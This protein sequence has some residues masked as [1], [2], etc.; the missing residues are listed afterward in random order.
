MIY[1]Y[2]ESFENF[3]QLFNID[4]DIIERIDEA[5]MD[6]EGQTEWLYFKDEL[7]DDSYECQDIARDIIEK[8][9]KSGKD[10]YEYILDEIESFFYNEVSRLFD[11]SIT[12]KITNHNYYNVEF[13]LES[14]NLKSQIGAG[15]DGYG[16]WDWKLHSPEDQQSFVEDGYLALRELL[17]YYE[18]CE[19]KPKVRLDAS[20]D[21]FWEY[22]QLVETIKEEIHEAQERYFTESNKQS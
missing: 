19:S 8:H 7:S 1:N 11:D 2:K 14:D 9:I 17:H 10:V 21:Y 13:T 22:D 6:D 20:T 16:E 18:A 5:I 12:L 4:K 15:M 3:I